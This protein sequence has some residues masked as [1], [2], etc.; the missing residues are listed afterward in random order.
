MLYFYFICALHNF[1][2]FFSI[3]GAIIFYSL[4]SI[5]FWDSVKCKTFAFLYF[6]HHNKMDFF[7]STSNVDLSTKNDSKEKYAIRHVDEES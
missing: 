6:C 2:A 4:R 7:R 3:F 5:L 1:I